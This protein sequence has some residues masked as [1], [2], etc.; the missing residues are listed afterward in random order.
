MAH[1]HS[2]E[3][4]HD[5]DHEHE[6][7]HAHHEHG[8]EHVTPGGPEPSP[9]TPLDSGAQALSEAL[10]SSFVIVKIVMV[11]LLIVF[12]GSGFFTVGPQER[13]MILRFG[14]PVGQGE[15]AL[16]MPGLHWSF[17]Y[18]IDEYIKVSITGIQQVQSSVGWFAVTREQELA[19]VEPPAGP[20]LNP[21]M[22]GYALTADSNIIHSKATLTY[23]I[24]DPVRYVFGFTNAAQTVRN[25]LDNAL[26]Y[27]AA[28]YT[29]D[30]VLT[31][32]VTGFK[33]TV[34]RRATELVA[35]QELGI[36]VEECVVES[37]PPRQL[38][39]AFA[40]VLRA[41]VNRSKVLNEAVSYRNQVLSR[42]SADAEGRINTAES[43][44]ARLLAEVSSR[45]EQFRELLPQ[46]K[47]NPNLFVQQRLTETLGRVLTNVQDKVFVAEAPNGKS[48]ELR[49]LF[50]REPPKP[51]A[52]EPQR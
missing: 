16:L 30:A 48:R 19:G 20:S 42:A 26:L 35:E 47:A 13:G 51:K 10:R 3:H 29:V 38:A 33:E 39:D 46:Y 24:N 17:P 36:T 8:H 4:P 12:L 2:H 43:D 18:P 44:R 7:E 52:E 21:A 28:R 25:A 15:S 5:H 27:A 40:N 14:K 22:D 11:V 1:D 37:R 50:N 6:H 23:R 45:A 32:D 9:E 49:L 41:E 34:R 31:R